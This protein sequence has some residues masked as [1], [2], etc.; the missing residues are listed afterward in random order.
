M[1][2]IRLFS[3]LSFPC[4]SLSQEE[5]H[6]DDDDDLDEELDDEAGFFHRWLTDYFRECR[7]NKLKSEFL[8][9]HD[10]NG[11]LMYLEFLHF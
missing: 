9:N 10:Y 7:L 4:H 6:D 1:H 3:F 2:D 11:F 5:E 8:G